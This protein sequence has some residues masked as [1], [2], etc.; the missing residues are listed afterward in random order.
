MPITVF[1]PDANP[2]STS[3]DGVITRDIAGPPWESWATIRTSTGNIASD[4]ATTMG[5]G[6]TTDVNANQYK[7]LSRVV[8]L[9][10][11]SAIPDEATI[12]SAT[13][14]LYANSKAN[15]FSEDWAT[16]VVAS[17]PASNTALATGDYLQ[18]GSTALSG[19]VATSAITTSAYNTWTLNAAGLAAISKTG[20]TKLALVL[21][22]D[23]S[24][25]EPA[26]QTSKDHS[27][28][29]QTSDNTNKPKLVVS[30]TG[31][32]GYAYFM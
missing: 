2:E 7:S 5:L 4:S 24:D 10:D 1:N 19:T 3:V 32:D 21:D 20:V 13:V 25:S 30:Y 12:N 17:T 23:R 8:L 31:S 6:I 9:F 27:V 14:E 16:V 29:F 11:T 28:V 26:H 15:S 18:T 22:R